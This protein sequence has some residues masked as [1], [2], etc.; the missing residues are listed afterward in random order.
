[1]QTLSTNIIEGNARLVSDIKKEWGSNF[2]KL[3]QSEQLWILSY[4][5]GIITADASDNYNPH[6]VRDSLVSDCESLT[7]ID[8]KDILELAKTLI[9]DLVNH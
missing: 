8:H 3:S 4:I 5:T 9:D 1:M 2:E 7:D 6:D